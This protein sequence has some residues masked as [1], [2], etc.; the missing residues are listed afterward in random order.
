MWQIIEQEEKRG[1]VSFPVACKRLRYFPQEHNGET[2]F[3]KIRF[4]LFQ[5]IVANGKGATL[6]LKMNLNGGVAF[7]KFVIQHPDTY[8][9]PTMIVG[10]GK[11]KKELLD[12]LSPKERV[13][14]IK[15]E[16]NLATFEPRIAKIL[17]AT[18][19]DEVM[20]LFAKRLGGMASE[21]AA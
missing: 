18:L 4:P 19:A 2:L 7:P 11:N 9:H 3:G 21:K 14:G 13:P 15:E 16:H 5:I 8:E 1:K 10:E 12:T 20:T 6:K 17:G